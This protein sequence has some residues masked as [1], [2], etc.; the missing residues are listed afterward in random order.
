MKDTKKIKGVHIFIFILVIV[1]AISFSACI[2]TFTV[3]SQYKDKMYPNVYINDYNISNFTNEKLDSYIEHIIKDV[4]ETN[5]VVT[6]NNKKYSYKL[7]DMGISLDVDTLKE[8]L[9]VF[10]E[11]K[12]YIN[13]LL[14][15]KNKQKTVFSLKLKYNEELVTKFLNDLKEKTL[16]KQVNGK[17]VMQS[18]RNLS[19]DKGIP[20]FILDVEKSAEVIKSNLPSVLENKNL[21]LVGEHSLLSESELS[22]IN[23]KISTYTT[24][25]DYKVSRATN[26]AFAA[27]SLDGVIVKPNETFSFYKYVGSYGKKGFVYYDGVI[28]NGVC[29][30]A[31]TL[32]N[33]ELLAGLKTIE[34]Y[35]HERQMV[36]VKGGLDATVSEK[37]G[38]SR[39]DFKFKNTLKY[40]IYISAYTNKGKLTI[41]FWSND[42]ALEGKSYKTLSEK[43][44]YKGYKTYLLTYKDGKEISKNFI[45]TTWYPK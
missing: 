44:G 39:L 23:T 38:R 2:Y 36:Y 33:V 18:D 45:A 15:I 7:R 29:Q 31:S 8:E 22:S 21:V 41:E 28:G 6:V 43:V 42:K 19:Y 32:Y 34:R 30:V 14:A 25:Y 40:P 26:V 9:N 35:S 27:K 5:I 24:T 13:K 20:S 1:I 10:K 11:E 3:V 17:L 16:V 4:N 37:S 12:D